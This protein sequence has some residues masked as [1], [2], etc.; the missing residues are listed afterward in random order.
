MG[1]LD[2]KV[3]LV[4]GAAQ[5]LGEADARALAAEGARVVLTD[6]KAELGEQVAASI[7]GAIFIQHDVSSD[8]GWRDVIARVDRE[9]GRL[10]VLVNNAGLVRFASIEDCSFAD[11]QLHMRVMADGT[12]LGCHHAIPLMAR[13][14][15]GGSIINMSSVAAIKGVGVIPAYTAAKG[16]ILSITR[17]IAVHCQEKGYGIRCNA[18]VPGAHDTPMTASAIAQLPPEEAGLAQIQGQGQGKPE[19]VANLV[20][21]LA[22]DK[23]KQINGTHIVIDNGETMG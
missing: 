4:T 8:D 17:S 22:S 18:L 6:V 21:F 9:F 2:G 5:G 3:A 11:W 7:P 14:G 15:D 23:G 10:D 12:F 16:A 1:L 20:V 13:S 19:D